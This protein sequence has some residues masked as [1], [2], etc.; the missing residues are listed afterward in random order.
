MLLLYFPILY[1]ELKLD[2]FVQMKIV[3]INDAGKV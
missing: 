2:T 1:F 3:E